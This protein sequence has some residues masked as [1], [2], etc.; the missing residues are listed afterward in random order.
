MTHSLRVG[1]FGATGYTGAE[2]VRLVAMHPHLELVYVAGNSTA[3]KKL[4]DALPSTLGTPIGDLVISAFEAADAKALAATIDVAFC[5]LPHGASAEIVAALYSEGL[6]VVDLSADFRL[7]DALEYRS[8]Y[9]DHPHEE[10]L[11]QA[12]Y[13]QPELH[14]QELLGAKLI[15]VPGCYPTAAQIAIA[16]L[17]QAGLL[18]TTLP[19]VIDAKS[20]VSG[21]GKAPGATTHFSECAEGIRPY[22]AGGTHRHTPEI[23]QELSLIAGSAITVSFTPQLVPMTRGILSHAYARLAAGATEEACRTTASTLFADSSITVLPKGKL[24]DTLWVR[25]TV[26]GLVAY[27]LDPR[28]GWLLC[29]SVID[30]LCRGASGQALMAFNA[31]MGW[32]ATLG[33]PVVAQFP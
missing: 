6:C 24:P 16:P 3:G 9:G 8:W 20:G 13:G 4:A 27:A 1:L 23:E 22:K 21:A 25:G 2:L 17:L 18:D 28:T 19:I 31:S 11:S 5:C 32:P 15:A 33:L 12:V 10:L 26:K 29:T 30:N 7:K 14:A